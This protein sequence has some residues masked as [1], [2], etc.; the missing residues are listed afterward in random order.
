MDNMGPGDAAVINLLAILTLGMIGS[1]IFWPNFTIEVIHYT[2]DALFAGVA[3]V[4][5]W[6]INGATWLGSL[7][8]LG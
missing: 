7:V 4:D 1:L 3:T 6:V 2:Y 5:T 8:G